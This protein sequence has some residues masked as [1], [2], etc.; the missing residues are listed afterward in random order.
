MFIHHFDTIVKILWDQIDDGR[1]YKVKGA[2]V[3]VAR[4]QLS[5]QVSFVSFVGQIQMCRRYPDMDIST[6]SILLSNGMEW[7]MRVRC[8][9]EFLQFSVFTVCVTSP[10][11]ISLDSVYRS[12][13]FDCGLLESWRSDRDARICSEFLQILWQLQR[14]TTLFYSPTSV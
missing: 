1:F 6:R 8:S 10:A 5:S 11:Y 4:L 9:P 2:V 12:V 7:L 14:L 3:V 13:E